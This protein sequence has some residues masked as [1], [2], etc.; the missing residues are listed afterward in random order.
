MYRHCQQS[1]F[2]RHSLIPSFIVSKI[3]FNNR[4]KSK[5]N[6]RLKAQN[7]CRMC[8]ARNKIIYNSSEKMHGC[9]RTP[10]IFIFVSTCFLCA[11]SLFHVYLLHFH[12]SSWIPFDFKQTRKKINKKKNKFFNCTNNMH[13]EQKLNSYIQIMNDHLRETE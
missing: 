11:I 9:E 10:R 3:E 8:N 12:P 6:F 7:V 13:L 1:I 4:I 2:G 5:L